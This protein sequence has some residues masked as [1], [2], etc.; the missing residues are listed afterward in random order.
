MFLLLYGT[1]LYEEGVGDGGCPK[2]LCPAV[3]VTFSWGRGMDATLEAVNI[4]V[5]DS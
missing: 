2:Y 1:G 3:M 4:L 5:S